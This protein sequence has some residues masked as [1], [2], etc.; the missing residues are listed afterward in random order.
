[1][2]DKHKVVVGVRDRLEIIRDRDYP[3]MQSRPPYNYQIPLEFIPRVGPKTI[4]KLID[5]FGSEMKVLHDASYEEIAEVVK[6]DMAR[7]IVLAR[8]G[9]LGIDVGGGGVYG[10]IEV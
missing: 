5:H 3:E 6:E 9:K 10:R 7:N 8:E 4:D 2:S 1:V